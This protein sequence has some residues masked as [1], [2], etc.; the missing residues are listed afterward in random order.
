MT[1]RN[2]EKGRESS[3]LLR[4]FGFYCHLTGTQEE[5]RFSVFVFHGNKQKFGLQQKRFRLRF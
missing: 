5:S 1:E 2:E 4:L 3:D